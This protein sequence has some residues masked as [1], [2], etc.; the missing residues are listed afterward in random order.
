MVLPPE[1]AQVVE[2]RAKVKREVTEKIAKAKARAKKKGKRGKGK[3]VVSL[4]SLKQINLNAAGLDIGAEEI[5]ACVPEGRDEVSVRVFQSYTVDLYGLADWLEACGVET[6]AMES[7]GVYWIP[8]YEIL[9][10]RGFE[11]Y[12][13][14]ARHVKNVDGRKTDV[15]DCQWVQQLHTYGLLRASFQPAEEIA[16]LRA[17]VRH[18]H[19]LIRYR[20]GHIQH[21]Q[22]ALLLMNIQ[23]PQVISDITGETGMD[24]IRAIVGGEH[25]PVKLAQFRNPR[26]ASS[27][28]EIAK[29]LQGNYRAEHLFAL[30]QALELYDF[31]N[32]QL[33]A[34]DLEIEQK[35]QAFKPQ[36]DIEAQPL[37]PRQRKGS[38]NEPEFDLRTYLYQMTGV[39]LTRIDGLDVLTVQEILSEIGLDMS[40]WPTVK[41]FTSWLGLA[42]NNQITGGKVRKRDTKK[43]TN[44]ANTALRIAAQS[45]GR[46]QSALGGFYRRMRTKHGSPKAITATAH[47]IARIVYHM[48]KYR[49]QYIDPGQDYYQQQYQDRVIKNLQRRAKELGMELVPAAN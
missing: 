31:Y 9:E 30:K 1:H 44:R 33:K 41:H 19:N 6:V 27:E 40:Q 37:P 8:I 25:D 14:N 7:T 3:R 13:V 11:V 5:W 32:Q 38:P 18:R 42:P 23:L 4:E 20:S 24:I 36:V 48:L 49:D 22:K 12:L 21:L 28:E 26:C 46:S 34:C 15:L 39:D 35:Y 17:Y 2:A 29:A 45:A 43:T 47:K 16:A 10:E